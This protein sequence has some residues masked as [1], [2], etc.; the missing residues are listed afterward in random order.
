MLNDSVQVVDEDQAIGPVERAWAA[1]QGGAIAYV[2]QSGSTYVWPTGADAPT[3]LPLDTAPEVATVEVF[4]DG[5]I[6][7]ASAEGRTLSVIDPQGDVHIVETAAEITDID[8]GGPTIAVQT[9]AGVEI[10][11]LDGDLR[12]PA[13]GSL[14]GA[15]SPDGHWYVSGSSRADLDEGPGPTLRLVNATSGEVEPFLVQATGPVS[16]VWWQDEYR[17][18]VIVGEHPRDLYSCT[19]S[20]RSCDSMSL[21]DETGTLQLPKD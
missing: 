6:V 16:D 12:Y 15:L 1:R 10:H 7:F 9:E 13:T 3:P 18:L 20:S 2:D 21:H 14:M 5:E 19:V 8:I 17:F 4:G 11:D